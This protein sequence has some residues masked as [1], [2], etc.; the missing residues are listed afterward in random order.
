VTVIAHFM[1]P[2]GL[3]HVIAFLVCT[4]LV[5]FAVGAKVAMYHPSERGT[6]PIAAA[7]AWQAK[8]M[9]P[10]TE[11]RMAA[12]VPRAGPTLTVL[13]S[14]WVVLEMIPSEQ[15]RPRFHL[16]MQGLPSVAVRPPPGF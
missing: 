6:R 12:I 10:D 7:K 14:L 1:R 2:K 5:I 16:Q 11:P 3:D 13:L 8:Q 15:E 9:L 4:L